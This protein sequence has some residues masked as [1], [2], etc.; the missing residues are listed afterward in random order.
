MNLD[1]GLYECAPLEL[2]E[3]IE[4]SKVQL[5][6]LSPPVPKQNSIS[7]K[8]SYVGEATLVIQH[9]KRILTDNGVI[10]FNTNDFYSEY[11]RTILDHVFSRKNFVQEY[12][13][14]F[15]SQS[16]K[17]SNFNR[18]LVYCKSFNDFTLNLIGPSNPENF[19]SK[20]LFKDERGNYYLDDLLEPILNPAR[21]F[22]WL[23]HELPSGMSWRFSRETLNKFLKDELIHFENT[24]IPKLKRFTS[25]I[26]LNNIW[27][28]DIL[29][30]LNYNTKDSY[31]RNIISLYTSVGDMVLD[32][33]L[34]QKSISLISSMQLG[35]LWIG[36]NSNKR[37][38]IELEETFNTQFRDL[39]F[40]YY[41]KEFLFEKPILYP[42]IKLKQ[43]ILS[44]L[45]FDNKQNINLRLVTVD[46]YQ[47]LT[48][49]KNGLWGSNNTSIKNW[50]IDD[51]IVFIVNK[52]IVALSVIT[53]AMFNSD[54]IV[55]DNG[56]FP[57]RVKI[58]FKKI[59]KVEDRIQIEGAIKEKLKGNWDNYGIPIRFRLPL[60]NDS[61]E[62]ILKEI[63]SRKNALKYY[64]ENIDM[65]LNEEGQNR[66]VK[67]NEKIKSNLKNGKERIEEK[68]NRKK[69]LVFKK[70]EIRNWRQFEKVEIDFHENLTIFIGINGSGK[71]TILNLLN[72]HFGWNNNMISS[73][74]QNYSKGSITYTSG[75]RKEIDYNVGESENLEIGRIL[76]SDN[77][78]SPLFVPSIVENTYQVFIESIPKMS[79]LHIPS[80]RPVY[81]F[82]QIESIPT[83]I[84]SLQDFFDEYTKSIKQ[85]YF[86]INNDKSP[87]HILKE[88]LITLALFGSG[89]G[90]IIQPNEIAH[91]LFIDFQRILGFV[92]PH[93][94]GFKSITIQLPEVILDTKSGLFSLD[95]V[96][97]GIAALIDITWQIFLFDRLGGNFI[98]TIDEP[99][100]HLHPEIQRL[101]LPNI[102]NA[103]PHIQFIVTTHNP[104]IISSV[105]NSN[106]YALR[107]NE[108]QKIESAFLDGVNKA[109]TSND[110]LIEA[111]GLSYTMPL[112]AEEKLE[113]ISD[114]FV[115][116]ELNNSTLNELEK[117]MNS[118]GL[119]DYTN[120]TL[121]K[122]IKEKYKK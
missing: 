100:N 97:G 34:T 54:D 44:G 52:K 51:F 115:N 48:C 66:V 80:H 21:V 17:K 15:N 67:Q 50:G 111:L 57:Y 113:T 78:E 79:G 122:I 90:D 86:S 61:A 68:D 22:M 63:N 106:I 114:K 73:P 7:T 121:E 92:L 28:N 108:N 119:G 43:S 95:S 120:K 42:S 8:S 53:Q 29:N 71:T 69:N 88:S 101:L 87:I 55:W 35:R 16:K 1:L 47:F 93:D 112:W 23:N 2:L 58:K 110:I 105:E 82:S 19:L 6:N 59:F 11:I 14:T 109:G 5:V 45:E 118:I 33:Y 76:Y 26:N 49:V 60:P 24:G 98:V 27:D 10:C 104:F 70:M 103:F 41:I 9:A 116:R 39:G 40:R 20:K 3:R 32:P 74:Q 96:S 99:E 81:N 91:Q 12:I 31:I 72:K 56:H 38:L 18:L 65:L 13:I 83:Q 75:T 89:Q 102:L 62:A 4:N 94:L 46:E 107:Y 30:D 36:C 37:T 117:D 85:G 64:K 84:K 77:K 25:N